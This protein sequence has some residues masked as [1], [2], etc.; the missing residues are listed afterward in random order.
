MSKES[1]WDDNDNVITDG[2]TEIVRKG[3]KQICFEEL[4]RINYTASTTRV[5]ASSVSVIQDTLFEFSRSKDLNALECCLMD[6]FRYRL[7]EIKEDVH[8]FEKEREGVEIERSDK[9][10]G[11]VL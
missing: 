10:G 1:G 4:Y 2:W 3:Y 5:E 6:E 7:N 11:T 9:D 8:D